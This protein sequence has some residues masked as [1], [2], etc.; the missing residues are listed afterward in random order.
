MIQYL[1]KRLIIAIPTLVII[2]III[3]TILAVAPGDPLSEFASNPSITAEVRENIRKSLGLDRPI[4]I[5][6]FKW[7]TSF[8]RGDMG[9]SFN[10]RSPVFQLIT[11]RLLTTF[12][13]VGIAYGIG[14]AIAFPLG[15]I[16]ALKRYSAFFYGLAVY[17]YL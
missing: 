16:S 10:S 7:L 14:L 9:Y 1:I 12:W 3:F 15:I 13:V 6:Y 5:R 8:I 4:Y 2:S 17:Y 11:Q